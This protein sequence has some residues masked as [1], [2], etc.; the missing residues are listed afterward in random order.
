MNVREGLAGV[1]VRELKGVVHILA[2][3]ATVLILEVGAKRAPKVYPRRV[4]NA[5]VPLNVPLPQP[6]VTTVRIAIRLS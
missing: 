4:T 5:I 1:Q 3:A 2:E 6:L